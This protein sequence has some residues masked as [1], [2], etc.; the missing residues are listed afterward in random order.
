MA[1]LAVTPPGPGCTEITATF[2]NSTPVVISGGDEPVVT[3]TITVSAAGAY[4]WDLDV[5]TN[6][7]HSNCTDL[8]ITLMSPAGTIVTLTT[9]NGG[10][11]DNIFNGTIWDDDANPGGIVP[12]DDNDGMV[13]DSSFV[14]GTTGTPLTPEEPL[15]AFIGEDPNGVWTLTI[16]DDEN[17]N[18]GVL[19]N[20]N[21]A[22]S[23]L[24]SAPTDTVASFENA[25]DLNIL[26]ESAVNSQIHALGLSNRICKVRVV[27]HMKHTFFGDLVIGLTSPSGTIVTLSSENGEGLDNV[28][29]GTQWDDDA[30]PAGQVPYDN[31]DGLVTD[32]LYVDL[33]T[34]TPLC[35]EEPFAAFI[36]EDPNGI[37]TLTIGDVAAGDIGVLE[38]WT[39][40]ITTC[41]YPDAD[42]DGV[43]DPCD[44]CAEGDDSLDGDGDGIPDACDPFSFCGTGTGIMLPFMVLSF[45]MMRRSI[46]RRF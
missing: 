4:L 7:T 38:D 15:G 22:V 43:G 16:S 39:L 2:T 42:G 12:Y 27:T 20:W 32:H 41:T 45:G 23:T 19:D 21:L 6:L 46:R 13:T 24:P 18:G 9:D 30:N 28:F 17:S 35:P 3:S 26:D 37:W 5:T 10:G 14:D 31:N 34:A 29:D 25:A 40:E 11:N 33:T 8:D 44:E 1:S 36:G